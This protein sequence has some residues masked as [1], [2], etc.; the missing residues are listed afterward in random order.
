MVC[1]ALLEGKNI[2]VQPYIGIEVVRRKAERVKDDILATEALAKE[3]EIFVS[4]LPSEE[5]KEYSSRLNAAEEKR[6]TI[7]SDWRR[8]M[9][10]GE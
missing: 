8:Q 4:Q 1:A 9:R 10:K 2:N 7:D 3:L 6:L 5:R